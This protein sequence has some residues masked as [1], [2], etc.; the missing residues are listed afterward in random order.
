VSSWG[1]IRW[2]AALPKG[3]EVQIQTRTG[4]TDNPDTTWTE[5]SAFY[6]DKE[7]DPLTSAKARFLQV[8]ALLT[9]TATSTPI[10]DSI[11]TA[12]LQRNLRPEVQGITIH[13]PGEV[14]QKPLSLS[15]DVEILGLDPT[16]D[17]PQ[18]QAQAQAAKQALAAAASPFSRKLFQKGIQTISWKAD[19]PNGDGLV[20]D[21]G[22]RTVGESRFRTLRSA[23]GDAVLAWDTSTVPNG[24]YVIRITARDTPGN[25]ESLALSGSKESDPFEIDNTPPSVVA[26]S[27]PGSPERVRAV[28][29][30]HDSLIRKAEYS[31]DGGRWR[32]VH[33]RDGINDAREETYEFTPEGAATGS[34]TIVVRATDALGNLG[35]AR[36][37]IGK[38]R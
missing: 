29:T 12:Y 25:P 35:T 23:L 14:F 24:R 28:A 32:E 16:P 34:H 7:G 27:V 17:S 5:W 4:N 2:E 6:R 26:E 22:Y 36:V 33:P 13:P 1:R 20:F 9:G 3:T 31:V 37:E 8:R 11:S 18:A 10:L 30:D 21:V 38:D 15:G 19:D